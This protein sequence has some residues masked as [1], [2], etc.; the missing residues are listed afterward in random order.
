MT[1][2]AT[3]GKVSNPGGY[4]LP[5]GM[6]T[7]GTL[8]ANH[9]SR[10]STV[11]VRAPPPNDNNTLGMA[12][13]RTLTM[14]VDYAPNEHAGHHRQASLHLQRNDDYVNTMG[15][16][17]QDDESVQYFVLEKPPDYNGP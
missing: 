6:N 4:L 12:T 17:T 7:E 10:N 2:E 8:S 9:H 5:K 14:P 11:L 15:C 16:P 1:M 3:Y 13:L